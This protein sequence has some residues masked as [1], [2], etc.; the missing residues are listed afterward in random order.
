MPPYANQYVQVLK[1]GSTGFDSDS[2]LVD[3][4]LDSDTYKPRGVL[5]R[6]PKPSS[7]D[8]CSWDATCE[9]LLPT[10]PPPPLPEEESGTKEQQQPQQPGVLSKIFAAKIPNPGSALFKERRCAECG[11]KVYK[12]R[13]GGYEKEVVVLKK[14]QQEQQPDHAVVVAGVPP[15]EGL[16][17][18]TPALADD[19]TALSDDDDDVAANDSCCGNS[20]PKDDIGDDDETAVSATTTDPADGVETKIYFKK[21]CYETR[22][23]R[24]AHRASGYGLVLAEI[25]GYHAR[26]AEEE[27]LAREEA[28]RLQ[29]AAAEEAAAEEAERRAADL[30]RA[31]KE[32][33]LKG[34]TRKALRSVKKTF[35]RPGRSGAAAATAAATAPK[36]EPQRTV[37]LSWGNHEERTCGDITSDDD[38]VNSND[39]EIDEVPARPV[40]L[41]WGG[42]VENVQ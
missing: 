6:A 21:S 41:S 28:D 11:S 36:A 7:S 25:P 23:H 20:A 31:A 39:N 26:K 37:Q 22:R 13:G 4:P 34:R 18:S 38:D 10:P 12:Y 30:R 2:D 35:S 32:R 40:Q 16:I 33:S 5:P 17:V 24:T 9:S 42:R 1:N 19:A 15:R 14:Q 3:I 8:E 29:R 27:R